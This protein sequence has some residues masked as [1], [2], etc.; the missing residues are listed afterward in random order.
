M[1]IIYNMPEE[2]EVV[3]YGDLD[4]YSLFEY[5][6]TRFVKLP[7]CGLHDVHED[8]LPSVDLNLSDGEIETPLED[9]KKVI[10]IKEEV[11]LIVR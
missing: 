6:E 4:F 3:T 2:E 10:L 7:C 8:E 5:D 9:N 1:G 11:D